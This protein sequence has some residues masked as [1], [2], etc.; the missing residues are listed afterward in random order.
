MKKIKVE[1]LTEKTFAPFGRVLTTEGRAYGGEEGMYK[2]YEKQAS[3]DGAECVAVNLLTAV[4]RD[5]GLKN[6]KLTRE[7][8]KSFCH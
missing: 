1:K 4:E 2:W 3:V 5:F 6:L 8:Q 7:Q